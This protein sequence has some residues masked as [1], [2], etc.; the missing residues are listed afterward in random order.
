MTPPQKWRIIKI[1]NKKV[2]N[3]S[4]KYDLSSTF[5][6]VLVQRGISGEINNILN[7]GIEKLHP[8]RLLPDI[9]RA[10]KK[11]EKAINN[12]DKIL[13]WG[14]EDTD[15]TTA[16]VLL[17]EFLKKLDVPV[18]YHI[19]SRENEGIGLNRWGIKKASEMGIS[20]L[21]TVDCGSSDSDVIEQAKKSGIYVIVT[22]HHEVKLKKETEYP[23][24]NPKRDDC[25]Y[26]FRDLAGVSVAFKFASFIANNSP[27]LDKSDWKHTVQAWYPLIF[28][29]SYADKVSLKDENRVMAKLGFDNLT[30]TNRVGLRILTDMLCKKK[31]CTEPMVRKIISVLSSAKTTNWRENIG[32]RIF[33]ENNEEEMKLLIPQLVT[34]SEM[35]HLKANKYMSKVYSQIDDR[36]KHG[37][38][39]AYI[40]DIPTTYLGFCTSRVKEKFN[41]PAIIITDKDDC[42]FGE[43]RAP[44]GYDVYKSL[45]EVNELFISFGGHKPAC[46]FKMSKDNLNRFKKS[47]LAKYPQKENKVRKKI[48]IVDILP[49]KKITDKIKKEIRLLSPFGSGN[50]PPLFLAR[51]VSLSSGTYKCT[52]PETGEIRK[53][54]IQDGNQSWMG[55]DGQPIILDI[56]YYISSAGVPTVVD[57]RPSAF[58]QPIE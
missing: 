15:G 53:I 14:D 32:F 29:G 6:K 21:I 57:S 39:V 52:N 48:E 1:D 51:N 10:A 33:T 26:P 45:S 34:Q 28:L 22:D 19:P 50:P 27:L 20:V 23:V 54:E 31:M 40:P 5:S 36:T 46:G 47:M 43:A 24:I 9:E 12:G 38:I 25:N 4:R 16:T 11:V 37:I 55:I 56:V 58:N 8:P 2:E 49:L 35:W 7:P 17:Y 18:Y 13:V 44:E 41:R 3:L 42:L 30:R